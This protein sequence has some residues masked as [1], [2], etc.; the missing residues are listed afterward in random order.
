M[1][2]LPFIGIVALSCVVCLPA[3]A[4]DSP[5]ASLQDSDS[6]LT[7]AAVPLGATDSI[8]CKRKG[9]DKAAVGIDI[10][11]HGRKPL[12]GFLAAIYYREPG[13]QTGEHYRLFEYL[14]ET[15]VPGQ[16]WQSIYCGLPADADL[17]NV[18][19]KVD[20]LAFADQ[21]I[22]GPRDLPESNRFYGVLEGMN[23]VAGSPEARYVAP[24]PV[25]SISGDPVPSGDDSLPLEFTGTVERGDSERLSLTIEATNRGSVPVVGYEFKIS[26][27]DHATGAFVRSV[28]TKTL[29][30]TGDA[31]DYL[32]SG[33]SWS[34]GTRR[35]SVS[36]DGIPDDYKITL[37]TVV[38]S[39]GR[40]LGPRRSR[41]SAELLGMLEAIQ[42]AKLRL[43][44]AG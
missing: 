24:V 43:E 33:A 25:A 10:E 20:V 38:L 21:S 39:D 15:I 16:K 4:Q 22:S 36:S 42:A 17:G 32:L 9:I 3:F 28:T 35:L 37:D 34:S 1:K 27:F 31:S 8:P 13:D 26:F 2:S 12:R 18:R 41:E 14:G 7:F 5:A 44:S 29:A 11:Y 23:Y 6:I 40:V 30:T 19:F